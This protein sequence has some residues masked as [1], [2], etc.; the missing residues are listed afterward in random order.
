MK[1][2]HQRI[3]DISGSVDRFLR[4]AFT[5]LIVE[6]PPIDAP[7]LQRH[8]H[9][10]VCTHRSHVDYFLIG[11][12]M[13]FRGFKHMRFAAG[14]N[15]TKLPWIG[16][17]FREFGAF[18][19]AR[20]IAFERNYV[21]NLCNQVVAM[22]AQREAVIVFP[23]GGRSYSGSMLE[24]KN[25]VL[26]AAVL[27]QSQC[28]GEDVFLLPMAI[29]YECPPDVP[30][31]DMLLAGKKLRRRTQPFLK[32]VLG[33]ILYFGADFLAFAPFFFG[34]RFKRRYGAVY[35][36]Y[37]EPLSVRA[38]VDI[39]GNRTPG[40]RGDSFFEHRAS[41]QKLAEIMQQR[42]CALYRILPMH[43]LAFLLNETGPLP[44]DEA[45]KRV[46]RPL[47]ALRSAGRNM[48]SLDKFQSPDAIIAEG[49]RQ[50][51][52]LKAITVKNGTIAIRKKTIVGY[53]AAPI[54]DT[55]KR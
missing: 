20:E 28:A 17:R 4:S 9:M 12:N 23:E 18:T 40:S 53:Y 3:I 38:A 35:I 24:V 48:K 46:P 44:Q 15:L 27:M 45:V 54:I 50:L 13:F 51:L 34:R 19:V 31:F 14:D 55:V 39:E 26:G 29:S 1:T 22:M 42:F 2:H 6:G 52:R 37:G 47:D 10:V 5:D 25:G 21:K 49:Q 7:A 41:M 16:V 11:H 8:P 32:R 30:W 36:D 33:T 43:I